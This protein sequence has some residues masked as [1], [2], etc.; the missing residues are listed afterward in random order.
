V[1][2]LVLAS[3][4]ALVS[5]GLSAAGATG[6]VLDQTQ[7]DSSGYL[8]TSSRS[9]ST[10]TYALVSASYRG[11]TSNDWF[12]ARDILGTV[13]FR[14]NSTRAV[15]IGIGPESAVNAYL[16]GV[17]HAQG[18][19]FDATNSAFTTYPGGP[20]ASLPSA[21]RFW[22]ASSVGTGQQ[23]LT[24]KP[25]NGNWRIVMMNATGAAAVS[26][27]VSVGARV[28]DLLTIGIAVLGGGILLLLLSGGGVYLAVSRRR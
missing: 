12:V 22:G 16:R 20:P 23:T 19:R 1:I 17:A 27:D 7:R 21:Q 4:A 13:R 14:V 10:S 26:G 8:M 18:D 15:F 5:L 6:I 9:Y 28:P 11:G 24:W 25:R 3:L 2:A